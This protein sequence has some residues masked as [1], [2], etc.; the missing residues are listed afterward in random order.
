M[1]VTRKE[2]IDDV[3]LRLTQGKPSQDFQVPKEQIGRWVD[4]ARDRFVADM[5]FKSGQYD[6]H[7][8]DPT[9]VTSEV[10]LAISAVANSDDD[11]YTA[12]VA[13]PILSTPLNDYGVLRVRV[14]LIASPYTHIPCNKVDRRTLEDMRFMEFSNP[15]TD[16]PVVYRK[17]QSLYFSGL[18]ASANS[19]YKAEVEYVEAMVGSSTDYSINESHL[20][21]ITL[22]AEEIGRREIGL[23]VVADEINDGS[24]NSQVKNNQ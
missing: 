6:G 15:S 8:I 18:P 17:G 5:L 1:S 10:D 21:D 4:I 19:L 20:G 23:P 13:N 11:E 16:S 22:M 7:F 2:I 14:K 9:Y 12:V 3:E 24:Q